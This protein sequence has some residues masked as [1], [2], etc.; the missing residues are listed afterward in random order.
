MRLPHR[1][2]APL[3]SFEGVCKRMS[4]AGRQTLVLDDVSLCLDA[5]S[6]LGLYGKRRSGKSTLL[7]LAA[8]LE[9]PDAGTVRFEGRDLA[10][11]SPG[12][13]A[14]LLRGPIALLAPEAW[15]PSA[16]ETV[17]DH[18]AVAA[19]SGG[20]SLRDARR[21]AL[22]ALDGAGVAGTC[23][24][25]SAASLAPAERARVMLARALV[26]D[27]RLL[28]VDE[29]TP[30]PSLIERDRFCALV[31]SLARERSIALLVASE[32]LAALQGLGA[33]ASISGGGLCSTEPAGT[34]VRFPGA[35]AGAVGGVG[36]APAPP[37]GGV[38]AGGAG[39]DP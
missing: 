26:R 36:G 37:A 2:D 30:M 35:R 22:A 6:T 31:R 12:A 11:C 1:S 34:V 39:A 17:L 9:R 25:E 32:D 14:R 4:E 10:A 23:M 15:M 3:L 8:G 27:P 28:L 16:G 21:R 13:R 38:S 19:G 24:R 7:R 5:R 20:V 29:P 33:L 18:V